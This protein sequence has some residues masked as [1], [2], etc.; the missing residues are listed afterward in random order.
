MEGFQ[1]RHVD[2]DIYEQVLVRHGSTDAYQS[3]WYTFPDLAEYFTHDL[4]LKHPSKSNYWLYSGRSDDTIVLSNGEKIN[5]NAMQSALLSHPEV[6]G[7]L[8]VG[9]AR[10]E[11]IALIELRNENTISV[12]KREVF[13]KTF[14][15]YIR[16]ANENA[17]SYGKLG[18]DHVLF[19]K[20][21][22]PM[23]RADKGTVKRSAT[24]E[25]YTQEIDDF[26][27]HLETTSTLKGSQLNTE[28]H[29][30]LV[31]SLKAL[32]GDV[33]K[34]E[35]MEPNDDFFGQGMN[36]L[37]AMTITREIKASVGSQNEGAA[38]GVSA[39]VIYSNPTLSKLA[40]AVQGLLDPSKADL[41]IAESARLQDMEDMVEEFS[42]D[43]PPAALHR[44][45]SVNA[46]LTLILTGSTGSLGS[47]MLDVALSTPNI[48]KV[49]CLNRSV[50]GEEKQHSSHVSRGLLHDWQDK[51][52]FLQSDLS[53]P[54][55]GLEDATYKLLASET[56]LIIRMSASLVGSLCSQADGYNFSPSDNQYPVDFNMAISSFKPHVRAVRNLVNFSVEA[57]MRPPIIFTS[58]IGT[59][60]NWNAKHPGEKV[61][62]TP[63]HDFG[64]PTPSGY[65]ESKY[66]AEQILE[67]AARASGV[68]VAIV[69]VGQ[70]G[71]PVVKDVGMWNKQ[72][73]LPSVS[74]PLSAYLR[75]LLRA[76][77]FLYK[78]LKFL[79]R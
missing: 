71:G 44:I 58:S 51:V 43:L 67:N 15:A 2:K 33:C 41:E 61:P 5:P 37:Q 31:A 52:L 26:Y 4:Y 16:K 73:W 53:K 18:Y 25:I 34:F 23:L 54:R 1:F 3:T 24:L 28:S 46:G 48:R 69:R 19:T 57:P 79:C 9:Q 49:I 68:P 56:T 65:A 11:A 32:I 13:D 27:D 39:K 76:A 35:T 36:S 42:I 14:R 77:H 30:S 29:D 60:G 7:A 74:L 50:D 45:R 72:E 8:I 38:R 78:L 75:K 40:S 12:G 63:F 59:L 70:L 64:I 6:K 20:A 66:V 21:G 55:L 10:F 47:Y 22:K 17:P 62:E